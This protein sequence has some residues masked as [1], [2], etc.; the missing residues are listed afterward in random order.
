MKLGGLVHKMGFEKTKVPITVPTLLETEI[1]HDFLAK[2]VQNSLEMRQIPIKSNRSVTVNDY[3]HCVHI[4]TVFIY[5]V[6][7]KSK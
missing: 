7:I 6:Q 4:L 3:F 2:K 1:T 5:N